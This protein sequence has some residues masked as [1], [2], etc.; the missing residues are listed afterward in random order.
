MII[1]VHTH[2]ETVNTDNKPTHTMSKTTKSTALATTKTTKTAVK[3]VSRETVTANNTKYDK[4]LTMTEV[5]ELAHNKKICFYASNNQSNT[6]R[7]FNGK[8][9]LHIQKTQYKLYATNDDFELLNNA[10]IDGV[11]CERDTNH[12]DGV[13]PNTVYIKPQSIEKVFAT[14]YDNVKNRMQ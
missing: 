5:I 14:M 4:V 13:R 8:S 12:V 7:I 1:Q 3:K 10:K 2:G 9:S 6:Y 11:T